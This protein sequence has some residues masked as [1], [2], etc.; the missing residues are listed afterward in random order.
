MYAMRIEDLS[1]QDWRKTANLSIDPSLVHF[2]EE[3]FLPAPD[4]LDRTIPLQG[5][6]HSE[7]ELYRVEIPTRYATCFAILKDGRKVGMQDS[8][9]FVG[10][11]GRDENPAYLFCNSGLH[12]EIQTDSQHPIGRSSPGNV[13]NIKLQSAVAARQNGKRKFIA[14]DGSLLVLAG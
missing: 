8:R 9:N 5:A 4:F 7:V 10:W 12:I 11:S 3:E 1:Q 6:S 14:P 13:C 2:D